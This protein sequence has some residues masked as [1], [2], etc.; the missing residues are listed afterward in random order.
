MRTYRALRTRHTAES[1]PTAVAVTES[2]RARLLAALG[3]AASYSP[4]PSVPEHTR[5]SIIRSLTEDGWDRAAS[6]LEAGANRLS[7]RF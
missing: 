7:I 6:R 3:S 4:E 2:R 1:L 5:R